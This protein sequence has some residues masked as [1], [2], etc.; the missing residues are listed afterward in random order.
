MLAM[1]SMMP[2]ASPDA[3]MAIASTRT[4]LHRG[5]MA[6]ITEMMRADT[7]KADKALNSLKA[8]R[9]TFLR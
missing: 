4:L 1:V 8:E 5:M 7:N 6:N 2:I 9:E 3:A